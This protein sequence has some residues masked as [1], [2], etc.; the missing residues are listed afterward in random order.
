VLIGHDRPF[1][2]FTLKEANMSYKTILVP[3]DDT[4][5]AR[6]RIAV[7]AQLAIGHGAHLIGA[8][9]TGVSRFLEEAVAINVYDPGLTSFLEKLRG[10]ATAALDRFDEQVGSLGVRSFERRLV[11]DEG[12]GG[13]S[14][15]ARY[16]DLVVLSQYDRDRATSR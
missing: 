10:R 5:Q 12:E 1:V 7:A 4:P 3:V 13:I 16:C 8:A 6:T 9:V 2:P 11:N 14:L 15:H